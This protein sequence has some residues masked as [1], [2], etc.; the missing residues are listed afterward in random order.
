MKT[1]ILSTC[2]HN[3]GKDFIYVQDEDGRMIFRGFRKDFDL[4]KTY[5]NVL[6]AICWEEVR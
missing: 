6:G 3:P 5:K 1:T 2:N 4:T